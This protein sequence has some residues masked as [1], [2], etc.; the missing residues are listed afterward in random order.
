MLTR[1]RTMLKEL[2][3][4]FNYNLDRY[5]KA[6]KFFESD[7]FFNGT[8]VQQ[9][10]WLREFHSICRNL[11]KLQK[12]IENILGRKMSAKETDYGFSEVR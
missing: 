8:P 7:K 5:S 4:Q 1:R 12:E 10:K 11:S 6:E 9:E 2:K 3:K